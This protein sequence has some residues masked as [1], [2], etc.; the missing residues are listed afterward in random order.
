MYGK[1]YKKV[2]GLGLAFTNIARDDTVFKHVNLVH[3]QRNAKI[4]RVAF[5]IHLSFCPV[6]LQSAL[7]RIFIENGHTLIIIIILS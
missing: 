2:D 1:E 7:S 3:K 6:T 4:N 5:K